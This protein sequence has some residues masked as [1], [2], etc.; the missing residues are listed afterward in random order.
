MSNDAEVVAQDASTWFDWDY[1]NWPAHS[2]SY[3]NTDK[4][5]GIG[6]FGGEDSPYN[7]K[8]EFRGTL[9]VSPQIQIGQVTSPQPTEVI[10]SPD[11]DLFVVTSESGI[12]ALVAQGQSNKARRGDKL[13]RGMFGNYIYGCVA[14][15]W[16]QELRNRETSPMRL[17]NPSPHEITSKSTTEWETPYGMLKYSDSFDKDATR[18]ISI[19]LISESGD[20]DPFSMSHL[21]RKEVYEGKQLSLVMVKATYLINGWHELNGT[22]IPASGAFIRSFH[23]SNGDYYTMSTSTQR[24]DFRALNQ[25]EVQQYYSDSL[26]RI[27]V[28]TRVEYW[29]HPSLQYRWDGTAPALVKTSN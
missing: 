19:E 11:Y 3:V 24:S 1:T 6:V 4:I 5:N 2:A 15:T 17:E 10:A 9:V 7:Q 22:L 12:S 16:V 13:A 23:Y 26:S 25:D 29:D 28:G 27:P 8:S 14:G 21:P 18:T 20:M